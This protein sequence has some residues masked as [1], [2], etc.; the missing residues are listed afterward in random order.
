MDNQNKVNLA[1]IAGSQRL[2]SNTIKIANYTTNIL[3]SKNN[4]PAIID[5]ATEKLP[6]WDEG[7][8]PSKGKWIKISETL[9]K[10][11]GFIIITPEWH[12]MVPAALK[13]FFLFCSPDELAHKPALIISVSA[14]LGGNY[15]IAEL[16]SSSYKNNRICYLP[17]HL[18]IKNADK[19]CNTLTAKTPEEELLKKRVEQSLNLLIDYSNA[20]KNVRKKNSFDFS[21]FANGM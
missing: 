20:L 8:D 9:Q 13:N 4:T 16:R 19:Y 17:E 5:L 3:K 12:G 11:D 18:I 1:I 15:P 21:K 6:F 2:K 10:S 14:G 7:K